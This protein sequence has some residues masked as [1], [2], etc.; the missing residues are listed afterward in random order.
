MGGLFISVNLSSTS[1]SL[2]TR[3]NFFCALE[4]NFVVDEFIEN[5]QLERE[6]FFLRRLLAF[7]T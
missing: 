7:G 1:P 5:I 4:K 3:F 6:R 2:A